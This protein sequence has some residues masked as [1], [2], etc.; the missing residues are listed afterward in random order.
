MVGCFIGVN[1]VL[2]LLTD[3]AGRSFG[4]ECIG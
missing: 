1:S 3:V 4:A 2:F